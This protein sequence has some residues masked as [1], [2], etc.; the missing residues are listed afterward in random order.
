M[1]KK[2]AS[3]ALQ[4]LSESGRW[5]GVLSDEEREAWLVLLT[6]LRLVIG[7]RQGVTDEVMERMPD[8]NDPDEWPL[9]VLHYLGALQESLVRAAS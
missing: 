1:K 6:D 3:I 7:E 9:A 4:S 5:H 2:N 8:P